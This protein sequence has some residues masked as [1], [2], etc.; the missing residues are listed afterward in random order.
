MEADHSSRAESSQQKVQVL[1]HVLIESPKFCSEVDD[2]SRTILLENITGL[3]KISVRIRLKLEIGKNRHRGLKSKNLSFM[4]KKLPFF[5]NS[6]GVC[7]GTV[8]EEVR[9][10]D[11]FCFAYS[12]FVT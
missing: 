5:P 3:L 9:S 6:G 7:D 2:M 1:L 12:L 10:F 4:T 8:E 11:S